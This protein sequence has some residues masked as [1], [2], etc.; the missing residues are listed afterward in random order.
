MKPH[1]LKKLA[2]LLAIGASLSLGSS[3]ASAQIIQN[4]NFSANA[5]SFT[6]SNGDFGGGSNPSTATGW[7]DVSGGGIE[8]TDTPFTFLGPTPATTGDFVY[9]F[10]PGS[11]SQ[12]ITLAPNTVY[13][14]DF[15]VA[16]RDG[17]G[18]SGLLNEVAVSTSQGGGSTFFDD[19]EVPSTTAFTPY[20]YTF[21]T[22]SFLSGSGDATITLL[23]DSPGGKTVDFTDVSIAAAP[24]P[25]TYALLG[26][27]ALVMMVAYRRRTA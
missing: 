10:G 12:T 17:D 15:S 3:Q 4:G 27:G 14:L 25:S 22:P 9:F 8:G 13:N 6:S 1:H 7:T 11:I 21:T 23:N 18:G 26:V 20:S 19:T 2:L 16:G 24:E 5:S